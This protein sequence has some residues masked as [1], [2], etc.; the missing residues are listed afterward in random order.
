MTKR[1]SAFASVSRKIGWCVIALSAACAKSSAPNVT[2]SATTP[3]A[4]P[5]IASAPHAPPAAATAQAPAPMA[6]LGLLDRL[7]RE[8]SA[9]PEGTPRTS[10]VI[11][12]IGKAGVTLDDESQVFAG[13]VKASYCEAAR[14]A[15]VYVSV[16]EYPGEAEAKAGREYSLQTF[17]MIPNRKIFVNKK[18]TLTIG[19]G[20]ASAKGDADAKKAAE[21][22]AKL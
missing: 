9:R 20:A 10:D 21:A 7:A 4:P 13:T 5:A 17:A 12:A 18:T 15:E 3:P 19:L 14:G 8:R 1:T 2:E 16:C 11:A 6:T 22:F